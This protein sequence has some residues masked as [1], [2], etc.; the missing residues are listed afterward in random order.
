MKSIQLKL[1]GNQSLQDLELSV[2]SGADYIGIVFADSKRKVD[3]VQCG[4]WL[5]KI[6]KKPFQKYVGIFVNPSLQDIENVLKYVPLDIIQCHGNESPEQ[7]T[8][9]KQSTGLSVW[10]AIHHDDNGINK[11]KEFNGIV[12]G[13]VI[14]SK[15][16]GAW[17]GTGVTFDWGS[18]PAYKEEANRQGVPCLIAGGITP[19]NVADI[20]IYLPPGIDISSGIETNRQKDKIKIEQL[21][22]R[23][24]NHDNIES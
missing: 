18:I 20:L 21:I 17:G 19:G 6:N 7:V 5:M 1:C 15:T 2:N 3:P 9:I 8:E 23:L 11:M 16:K 14:D 13:Y 22:E 24:N 12:D 4:Q 10:K